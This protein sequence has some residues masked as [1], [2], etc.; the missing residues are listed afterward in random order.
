MSSPTLADLVQRKRNADA[1]ADRIRE[2]EARTARAKIREELDAAMREKFGFE[3]MRALELAGLCKDRDNDTA[4][5]VLTFIYGGQDFFLSLWWRTAM[6]GRREL[7]I[8]LS[9]PNLHFDAAD[10]DSR[11]YNDLGEIWDTDGL[12]HLLGTFTPAQA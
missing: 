11:I 5:L 9:I 8:R 6:P 1:E 12:L 4:S 3:I 2:E 10:E 7:A